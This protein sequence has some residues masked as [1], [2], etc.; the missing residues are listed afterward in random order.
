MGFF[1]LLF[2]ATLLLAAGCSS[3]YMKSTPLWD[4]DY[5]VAKGP[6]GDRVNLWPLAYYRDPALSVLWPLVTV[7]DEGH[8]FYPFYEYRVD[9]ERLALGVLH[10]ALPGLAVM[11]GSKGYWRVL[12]VARSIPGD[13]LIAA[14]LW[15]QF[16]EFLWTPLMAMSRGEAEPF[17]GVLGPLLFYREHNGSKMV[18]APWPLVGVWWNDSVGGQLF[19]L[20]YHNRTREM[21]GT[22]IG[23]FLFHTERYDDRS[24]TSYLMPLGAFGHKEEKTWNQFFPL[25]IYRSTE[26]G[27]LLWAMF[28]FFHRIQRDSLKGLGIYPLFGRYVWPDKNK[29]LTLSLPWVESRAEGHRFRAIPLLLSGRFE[30]RG[31]SYTSGVFPL[32]HFY[33][34]EDFELQSV[35]PLFLRAKSTEEDDE[36]GVA[37][38]M[39][40]T[41]FLSWGDDLMGGSD[42]RNGMGRF[43]NLGDLLFH[44]F[45]RDDMKQTALLLP[46]FGTTWKKDEGRSTHLF[47]LFWTSSM[48][49]NANRGGIL[50]SLLGKWHI[51]NN[52]AYEN[53]ALL[54]QHFTALADDETSGSPIAI[55]NPIVNARWRGPLGLIGRKDQWMWRGEPSRPAEDALQRERSAWVTP[56]WF[57][58]SDGHGAAKRFL[59][60]RLYDE[61]TVPE[62]G[63]N[64]ETYTRQRVLWRL[65]HR[66]RFGQQVSVDAFPFI[67]YD[68][69]PANASWDFAGGLL[70]YERIGARKRSKLLWMRF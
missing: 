64:G 12:T 48:D 49:D 15:F 1:R 31:G 7:S 42:Y 29:S 69:D 20:F 28:P 21:N 56:F 25:W 41:P 26:D 59:L 9:T 44:H 8:S 27:P 34:D 19:P 54:E 13:Y 61:K 67:T 62:A 10:P 53:R 30:W 18:Y 45:C 43:Y 17:F 32:S 58:E 24:F 50:L 68:Q 65:W 40:L 46:F 47:P 60:G 35:V 39:F 33:K 36:E 11:D 52:A 6:A 3:H 23:I 16:K 51:S 55:D 37:N 57:S 66:E 22:N 14:P 4:D 2:L 5:P 63:E 70:G 38:Q